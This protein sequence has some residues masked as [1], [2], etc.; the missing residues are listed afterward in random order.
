MNIRG[1]SAVLFRLCLVVLAITYFSLTLY[2]NASAA[3]ITA[4]SL[5]L[6][7]G[8]DP[9]LNGG[10]RPGAAVNHFFQ[11]TLPAVG[12]PSVLRLPVQFVLRR[13]VLVLQALHMAL[14]QALPVFH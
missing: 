2:S 10:S 14:N 4:R 7:A 12:N 9:I 13:P 1:K 5:T 11:F 8:A 6:Q 3:Q